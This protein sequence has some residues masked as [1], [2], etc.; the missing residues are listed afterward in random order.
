M[1]CAR[2]PHELFIGS[3]LAACPAYGTFEILE[4][5]IPILLVK[6]QSAARLDV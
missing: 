6:D 4:A 3:L 5:E 1:E 2:G